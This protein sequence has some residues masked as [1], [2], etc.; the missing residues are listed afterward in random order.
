MSNSDTPSP[1]LSGFSLTCAVMR[2]L[3]PPRLLPCQFLGWR[4]EPLPLE[5]PVQ[6]LCTHNRG[7]SQIYILSKKQ[8]VH[9]SKKHTLGGHNQRRPTACRSADQYSVTDSTDGQICAAHAAQRDGRMHSASR[10]YAHD[11]GKAE[12]AE[13]GGGGGGRDAV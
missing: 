5:A 3:I 7:P 1:P 11:D 13:V 12:A 6:P 2:T 4:S 9:A 8:L 10:A